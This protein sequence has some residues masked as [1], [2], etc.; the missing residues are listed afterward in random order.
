[1]MSHPHLPSSGVPSCE[2]A[3]YPSAPPQSTT[4]VS[5]FMSPQLPSLSMS[6]SNLSNWMLENGK[7][8]LDFIGLGPLEFSI[9]LSSVSQKQPTILTTSTINLLYRRQFNLPILPSLPIQSIN[10]IKSTN[11]IYYYNYIYYFVI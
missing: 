8:S 9:P 7:P 6:L 11:P 2:K 4:M 1:M 10:S 3:L 5:V